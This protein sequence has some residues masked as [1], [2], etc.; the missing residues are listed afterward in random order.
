MRSK[1]AEQAQLPNGIASEAGEGFFP[2]SK[3]HH[4]L[5]RLAAF[6]FGELARHPLP[7]GERAR[8][9]PAPQM[10]CVGS[11]AIRNGVGRL[12]RNIHL[13]KRAMRYTLVVAGVAAG[14]DW[15]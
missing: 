8:P 14:L 3:R 12:R 9:G 6:A 13:G 7:N 2:N 4:P 10:Q 5:T 15:L 1:P 11:R